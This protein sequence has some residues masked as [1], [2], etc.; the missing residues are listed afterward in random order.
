MTQTGNIVTVLLSGLNT[1]E[2]P[3]VMDH[4][5]SL[6]RFIPY[7]KKDMIAMCIDDDHLSEEGKVQFNSC[8]QLLQALFHFEFHQRVER[9][10]DSFSAVNPDRD[11][12]TLAQVHADTDSNTAF[13]EELSQLLD[14]ANFEPISEDDLALALEEDS[15][16]KIKL[17]VNFD[18]FS[19]VLLYC[20]GESEREETLPL[21]FGLRQH[22]IQFI[23]YDRVVVY[24]RFKEDLDPK[25]AAQRGITSGSVILK[26]FKNVPKADLEM[27]FPNTAVRMRTIDKL[28]IGVPALISGGV[29]ISTKLGA[30]LIL[31]GSVFGFWLGLHSTPV[32]F[33]KPAVIALFVGL[34][35][36]GSYLWKQFSNFKNRKL[37]FV[38]SLTQNL[39][40][41]NL[42]NNAGV[43]HRLADDAEEEECKEAILAYYFLLTHTSP[44]TAAELD[45]K[46]EHWFNHK[47]QCTLNFEIDDALHKLKRLKLV[48]ETDNHQLTAI[49]LPEA[50][51]LLDKHWD[52][53]FNY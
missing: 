4:K 18:E 35:A 11:T 24:I 26:L 45:Q 29:V 38:Q 43:F 51:A 17:H 36:V 33:D 14:K 46:I 6:T 5:A 2:T 16:F 30:T 49:K 53:L 1:Q 32:E 20:R 23:N 22:K 48:T 13:V 9:L 25:I 37:R 7:R 15:L 10:K 47:H 8:S 21:L 52:Q 41:K 28:M 31:L 50:L 27:L 3:F 40:F 39:Y 19:E 12:R 34:G 42:D 44:M